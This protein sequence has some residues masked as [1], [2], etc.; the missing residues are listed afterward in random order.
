MSIREV[1]VN[2][3]VA[4]EV[5]MTDQAIMYFSNGTNV[6]VSLDT[7]RSVMKFIE[8]RIF[9]IVTVYDDPAG[10]MKD[11]MKGHILQ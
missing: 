4:I 5:G 2:T 11:K 6:V 9:K 3:V 10:A 7:A 8:E 1:D